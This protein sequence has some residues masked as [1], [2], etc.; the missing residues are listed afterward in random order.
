MPIVM[1]TDIVI[2]RNTNGMEVHVTNF[3]GRIQRILVPTSDGQK[4]DVV[5]GFDNVD[6]YR[7]ERNLQDFGAT[8]GRYANRIGHGRFTLDGTTYQLPQNNG[9]HCLHGGP[10]GWQYKTFD[11]VEQTSDSLVLRHVSPDGDNGFPGEVTLTLRFALGGDNALRIDYHAESSAPTVVNLTNHSY[12][13]LNGDG[14]TDILNHLMSICATRFTLNDATCLP[15]G[16]IR[17]VEGTPMDFR[18]PKSVGRDIEADDGQL[19]NGRGY[20]HN[21][22]LDTKGDLYHP[23]A[24]LESP[25]TGIKMEVYTDQPGLQV[26]TGNFLDGSVVGKYGK[27]YQMRNAICLETQ[28]YPDSPNHPEWTES[29]AVLRPE[30][31]FD[32]TTIF[33]FV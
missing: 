15:T 4:H 30:K 22:I 24:T 9:D 25:S 32:T 11:I 19:R 26:Y 3:G 33:K 7:P 10:D 28:H 31:P 2:L 6:D 16:E 18:T 5:L 14:N 12:F 27:R 17:C 21:W 8:I 29:D 1:N 20:D 23:C 13:N